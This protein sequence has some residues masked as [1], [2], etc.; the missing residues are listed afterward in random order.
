MTALA[1][2]RRHSIDVPANVG[3]RVQ[4]HFIG[5]GQR[6]AESVA[7]Y[8]KLHGVGARLEHRD[9]ACLADAASQTIDGAA[10][11]SGMVREVVVNAH[12]GHLA[13]Q[14]HAALHAFELAQRLAGLGG[15]DAGM[16]SGGNGCQCIGDIMVAELI[17]IHSPLPGAA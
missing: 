4:P 5:A 7:M 9:H 3:R 15:D 12:T 11:G 14:F 8:A 6:R 13:A 16:P 2:R 10:H 1:E 17:P